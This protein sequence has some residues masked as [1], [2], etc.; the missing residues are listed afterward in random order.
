MKDR[1]ERPHKAT[2]GAPLRKTPTTPAPFAHQAPAPRND[3]PGNI[4]I[5]V[6]RRLN[7]RYVKGSRIRSFTVNDARVSDV[8]AAVHLALFGKPEPV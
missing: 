5:I 1:Y 6:M 4:Q 8:A 7:G 2:K 3:D